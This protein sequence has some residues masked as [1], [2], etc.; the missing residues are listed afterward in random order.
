[1]STDMITDWYESEIEYHESKVARPAWHKHVPPALNLL[2]EN[3]PGEDAFISW[4]LEQETSRVYDEDGE[5]STATL[6][7]IA[8]GSVS[9]EVQDAWEI[10]KAQADQALAMVQQR[11]PGG[12]V[13][14]DDD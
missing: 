9:I 2:V 3:I 12:L 10:A 14:G 6:Q 13:F 4:L 8:S 1:M 7:E 11:H 5:V